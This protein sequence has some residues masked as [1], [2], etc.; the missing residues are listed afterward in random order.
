MRDRILLP[1]LAIAAAIAFTHTASAQRLDSGVVYVCLFMHNEDNILGMGGIDS[2]TAQNRYLQNRAALVNFIR[3]LNSNGSAFNWQPEW[4]FLLGALRWDTG[5]VT[6]STN[7]KNIV[8]WIKEDMGLEVDP[9]SHENGGYNYAD[10]AH[11]IDSLGVTPTSVIGG[12]VWDPDDPNFQHWERFRDSLQGEKYPWSKWYG[13]LLIGSGTPNHVNDPEPSG[14]WRPA[15]PQHYWEDSPMG[16]VYAVGQY[17]GDVEGA[18][19]LVDLY[20]TGQVSPD[21]ILTVTISS[22]QG[23]LP[24]ETASF[25]Q[26][27]VLPLLEMEQRGEVRIVTFTELLEIFRT[28]YGNAAHLYNAPGSSSSGVAHWTLFPGVL[29]LY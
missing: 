7:G 18:R 27:V 6:A 12:H 25:E 15:D 24:A 29:D 5:S 14:L 23:R 9:H 11:L 13:E 3:M 2:P 20:K 10:V 1:L 16:N 26:D 21:S 19:A 4:T 17:T 8:R 22:S 28:R